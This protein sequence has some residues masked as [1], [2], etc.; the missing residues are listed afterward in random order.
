MN[1]CVL[2]AEEFQHGG[3]NR[4]FFFWSSGLSAGHAPS[5]VS[6]YSGSFPTPCL[7]MH[8]CANLS[9]PQ[10]PYFQPEAGLPS[11]AKVSLQFSSILVKMSKPFAE[12]TSKFP[13]KPDSTLAVLV[14]DSSVWLLL[15]GE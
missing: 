3:T 11:Q 12:M 15:L 4:W 1:G 8:S 2:G 6:S 10:G 13:K 5:Y 7:S 9:S 14:V